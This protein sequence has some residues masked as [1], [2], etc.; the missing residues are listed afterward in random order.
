MIEDAIDNWLGESSVDAAATLIIDLG[1]ILVASQVT[2]VPLR[3]VG[4][5]DVAENPPILWVLF[6]ELSSG[7]GSS[8]KPDMC[9]LEDEETEGDGRF[10]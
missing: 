8:G 7:C 5:Y 3:A 10:W 9:C 2:L 4:M 6:L 1:M